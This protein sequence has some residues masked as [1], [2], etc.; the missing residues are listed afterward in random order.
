MTKVKK[1]SS[2]SRRAYAL[3]LAVYP[4]ER[5]ETFLR[6]SDMLGTVTDNQIKIAAERIERLDVR[7]VQ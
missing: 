1:N 2:R 4:P 6:E 7:L 5:A 3:M